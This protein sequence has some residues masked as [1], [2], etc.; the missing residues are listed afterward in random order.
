LRAHVITHPAWVR[1]WDIWV[2]VCATAAALFVPTALVLPTPLELRLVLGALFTVVFA[3]DAAVPYLLR[4]SGWE[5]SDFHYGGGRATPLRLA[6]DVV[7]A[8]PFLAVGAPYSIHLLWLLKLYRVVR[9]FRVWRMFELRRLAFLRL[10]VF[11]YWLVLLTH[12][13][14]TGWIALHDSS[15][16]TGAAHRYLSGLYFC[17][18]TLATVGYGDIVPHTDG[19]RLYAILL[20]FI[21]I[22]VYGFVIGNVAVILSNL[23]PRRARHFEQLEELSAFMSYRNIPDELRTRIADYY[24]YLWLNRLDQ[25]ESEILDRL[26]QS[27]R[28]EVSLHMK[29]DLLQAVPLFADASEEFLRDVAL[30]LQPLLFLPA[31]QVIRAGTPGREM[32]FVNRGSVE[33]IGQDGTPL[34][35]LNAG[36]FFGEMALVY[37]TP[38]AATVRAVDHCHLYLLEHEQFA[39]VLDHYPEIA[40]QIKARAAERLPAAMRATITQGAPAAD[41]PTSPEA[42]Q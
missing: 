29:R 2:A 27:L 23:D 20:M 30:E 22:G 8:L 7:A 25:D 39:V 14:T 4:R 28:M 17:I 9:L 1:G 3:F 6:V 16:G 32:Y 24:R 40:Q 10:A 12:S 13:L 11:A 19:Q 35:Q 15:L 18:T 38:R 34:A 41:A 21:G 36:D 33:V 31:D 37:Q 5:E 42:I 26:P